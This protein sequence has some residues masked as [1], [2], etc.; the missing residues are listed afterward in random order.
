M[1][2]PTMIPRRYF[3]VN[4]LLCTEAHKK[5]PQRTLRRGLALCRRCVILMWRD[6]HWPE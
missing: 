6:C 3:G 2:D 4:A 5:K 1:N